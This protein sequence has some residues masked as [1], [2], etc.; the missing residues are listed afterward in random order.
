MDFGNT[1]RKVRR[2]HK[3][4]QQNV[5]EIIGKTSMYISGI[6]SG[7]N[8]PLKEEDLK[9]IYLGV[10]LTNEERDSLEYA[11]FCSTGR[12]SAEIVNYLMDVKST[13]GLLKVLSKDR[14]TD[15]DIRRILEYYY[16]IKLKE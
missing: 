1:L 9:K 13:Y 14:A 4:T 6:E 16:E 7:K 2:N 12:V 15:S 8:G 5:A 10:D 11:A 3:L